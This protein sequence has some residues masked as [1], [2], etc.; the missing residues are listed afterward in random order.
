[1]DTLIVPHHLGRRGALPEVAA[2]A[3]VSVSIRLSALQCSPD[4]FEDEQIVG[5]VLWRST[6]DPY[7]SHRLEPVV[8]QF[9]GAHAFPLCLL[10]KGSPEVGRSA[11]L[12]QRLR[13]SRWGWRLVDA[14]QLVKRDLKRLSD[15]LQ[16]VE[17]WV[18]EGAARDRTSR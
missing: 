12:L 17:R 18:R 7:P 2:P 16:C 11:E 13:V 6:S 4:S 14:Q 15:L 9:L 3:A 5:G 1:M 8:L 10:L